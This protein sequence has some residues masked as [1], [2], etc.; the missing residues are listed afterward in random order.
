MFTN[1]C[2]LLLDRA[3]WDMPRAVTGPAPSPTSPKEDLSSRWSRLRGL[4]PVLA[5]QARLGQPLVGIA[6]TFRPIRGV[7]WMDTIRA[8]M[9]CVLGRPKDASP[10]MTGRWKP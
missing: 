2:V 1:L 10:P 4:S 5:L 3:Y 9:S 7:G 6:A 8:V